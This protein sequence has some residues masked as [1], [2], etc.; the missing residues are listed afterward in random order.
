MKDE[1][2][3]KRLREIE[4]LAVEAQSLDGSCDCEWGTHHNCD[5]WHALRKLEVRFNPRF[6]IKL[7]ERLKTLESDA[8]VFENKIQDL[9]AKNG[10]I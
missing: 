2:F 5:W 3:Q 8:I 1:I 4:A 7:L 9:M 6:T 10:K